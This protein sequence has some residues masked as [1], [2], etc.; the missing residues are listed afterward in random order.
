[1][2]VSANGTQSTP[3]RLRQQQQQDVC[4]PT[5]DTYISCHRTAAHPPPWS[6]FLLWRV[7]R[8][9][10]RVRISQRNAKY[11]TAIAPVPNHRFLRGCRNLGGQTFHKR[12]DRRSQ[13]NSRPPTPP[14]QNSGYNP[15]TLN[16]SRDRG[17]YD[18][19]ITAIEIGNKI[20][21]NEEI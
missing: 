21:N 9:S 8:S 11:A 10:D 12:T 17:Q 20:G 1:V 19:Y 18:C 4:V 3:L 2:Y 6:K 14:F 13:T 5:A 7:I 15:R 16:A